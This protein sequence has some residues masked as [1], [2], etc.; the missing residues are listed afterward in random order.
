[1]KAAA[2]EYARPRTVAEV[3][4]LLGSRSDAKV[5]AGGQTLGPMLNLRLAQ[6]GLVVD[7]TRIAEL[8]AVSEDAESIT[9]GAIV[10]HAAIEDGGVNDPIGGFL[11]RVAHGIGYRAVRTRGTIG[12]SLAHADPAA[13]WLSSLTA[14][15]AEVLI[16]GPQG[17]RRLPI[18]DLVRGAMESEVAADELITGIRVPK[19]SPAARYGFH[20]ICR[21]AG[22]FAD[23]IGVV[24]DDP[25]RDY[26]RAVCG[27]TS[28]RPLLLEMQ[29]EARARELASEDVLARLRRAGFTG[30][31]YELKLHVVALQRAYREAYAA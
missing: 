27:A 11:R 29:A 1:M 31:G 5:L 7:I 21:K 30:D 19:F 12:G 14:L 2:F 13:D 3:V 6:P 16:A 25:A 24:V 10:T 22:E 15:G 4:A 28:G 8:A 18:S 23:A 26:F 17:R 9:V 20:K